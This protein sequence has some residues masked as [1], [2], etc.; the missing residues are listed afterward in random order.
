VRGEEQRDQRNRD[1]K[2]AAIGDIEH[3]K[4][5]S[6]PDKLGGHENLQI[7]PRPG[8]RPP[9]AQ[10]HHIADAEQGRQ[11]CTGDERVHH[12]RKQRNADDGKSAPEGSLGE[13][14]DEDAKCRDGQSQ[15]IN[16]QDGSCR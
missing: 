10:R 1:G 13:R 8:R 15:R 11:E 14:D 2:E 3:Q 4:A 7:R 5:E 16:H 9:I 6:H 12:Q